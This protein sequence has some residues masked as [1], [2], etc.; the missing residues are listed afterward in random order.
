[1]FTF[2]HARQLDKVSG[3]L[4]ARAWAFGAGP[5]DVVH[6]RLRGGNAHSGRGA[7]SFL[8]ETFNRCARPGRRV[9]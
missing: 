1:M 9:R 2:G 5:G 6:A 4:L 7:A 3:E 8:T